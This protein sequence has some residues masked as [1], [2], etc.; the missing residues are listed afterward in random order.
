MSSYLIAAPNAL[1]MASGDLT[2]IREA[3]TDA[4]AAAVHPTTGIVA[5]A[6]DEVSTAIAKLF[7]GYAEEFQTLTA[8]TARLHAEFVR[9]LDAAAQA[10]AAA[11]AANAQ[12]VGQ[13]VAR[14]GLLPP[15]G[16]S[17]GGPGL[18][19]LGAVLNSVTNAVGLGG[20]INFPATVALSAPA[21]NGVTGVRIGFSFLQIPIGPTSLLGLPIPQFSYP[22]P[23][24]WYFPTQASGTVNATGTVYL[25][26]GFGAF[27]LLYQPLALQLAQQTNS[28]VVTPTIPSIPLPLG[29]WLNSPEMQQGV[30][31]LFLGP[32][33]NLNISA[34]HAGFQGTLPQDFVLSGHSAGGGLATI[35]A[36]NYLAALGAATNHLQGVV[37]FDGVAGNSAAFAGAIAHLQTANVPVYTVAASPQPWNAFGATTNQLVSLYPHAFVGAEIVGGSHVDSMLG[38]NPVT[39]LILQLVTGFSPP[40]ATSAVYTLSAGWINDLRAG[41]G[42]TS[43][44]HYGIYGPTGD[45]VPPGGQLIFLGPTAA[46]ILPA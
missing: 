37:M 6:A 40:G 15:V 23:A 38:L 36:G 25:Q 28:V 9:A 7:G 14:L 46:I 4:A 45:Y 16:L 33:T 42:P 43:P 3:I 1:T 12:T 35:A 39:D 34:N 17:F 32:Q 5:A 13:Q 20:V 44:F 2:A 22:A 27:G 26:H 29:L 19:T 8:Q 21:T 18:A 41:Y 30:A 10:Y 24:F 11:E 31:S